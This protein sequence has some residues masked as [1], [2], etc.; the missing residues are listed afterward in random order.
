MIIN[1]IIKANGTKNGV[2]DI[3]GVRQE[4][5]LDEVVRGKC[6]GDCLDYKLF[7]LPLF[8]I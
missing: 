5:K 6:K 8:N 7:G 4:N 2:N 3:E 1:A